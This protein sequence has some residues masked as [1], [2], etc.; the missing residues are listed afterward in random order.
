MMGG[1]A[2]HIIVCGNFKLGSSKLRKIPT[3]H[4]LKLQLDDNQHGHN[5]KVGLPYF[6]QKVNCHFPDRIKDL[7]EIA[8]YIYG[9]DR[10][11]KRGKSDQLEYHNWSRNLHFHL[12]VR[13]F[14][15]WSSSWTK[16][17]LNQLLSFMSGD[18]E[19]LFT[20]QPGARDVGQKNMF[21]FEGI[22]FDKKES[23]VA[24]F[25]GGLDSLAGVIGIMEN[26]NK[27]LFLISHRSNNTGVKKIQ[28]DLYLRLKAD[29]P[30][31]LKL[32]P[33]ECN[34]TGD[35]AIE[36]TQRTRMFLYASI[37]V[38][39]AIHTHDSKI[40]VFENGITSI[41]IPK[42]QDL[43]NAR[44][45]RTTHP[46]TLHLLEEFFSITAEKKVTIEHPFI[47]KTKK[48]I[49]DLIKKH[50]K[51]QY[52]N[53]TLSCTKSFQ[54]FKNNSQASHCGIC[55]QCVDRRFSAFAAEIEDFDAIY[56]CDLSKDPIDDLEGKS[57]INSYLRFNLETASISDLSF[58]SKH[59][60]AITEVIDY[61]PGDSQ[62]TRGN[63]M[64]VLYK[65]NAANCISALTR[66]RSKENILAP[67]S[68]NTLFAIIDDRV[69]LKSPQEDFIIKVSERLS[70]IIPQSFR[71]TKP[72]HENNLN[73]VINAH[74]VNEL[75]DY[76]REFPT[77][78]FSFGTAIPD[79]SFESFDLFIE[80]KY[81]RKKS[82]KSRITDEIAADITKYP[83]EKWKLFVIYDPEGKITDVSQFQKSFVKKPKVRIQII[84]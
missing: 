62:L 53:S 48:E 61:L 65:N 30:N 84:R 74:L 24:L 80:A 38:S 34:L 22:E 79:H 8:G 72:S 11:I 42:R 15:F 57:H 36:E 54:K 37:A 59:L 13:D 83:E 21:D 82:V 41:N 81:V 66:I 7:L 69:Y 63:L 45:S 78:R 1:D 17:L 26:T 14:K 28:N 10:L 20:F 76:E 55:S 60:D 32:F 64:F 73:D 52:I 29:Y 77:V 58:Y 19:Y 68:K 23:T 56:D 18:F 75:E 70:I 25:S 33:F 2:P 35:R 51:E 27:T 49:F 71:T 67:K 46:K 39:L 4:L 6:I 47:Y 43:I 16:F 5:I 40:N 44:A 50:K 12:K 9:A 3:S 31:R